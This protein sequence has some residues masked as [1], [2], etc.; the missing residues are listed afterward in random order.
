MRWSVLGLLLIG[1]CTDT[2]PVEE[3]PTGPVLRIAATE[4]LRHNLVPALAQT[5]ENTVGSWT[6]QIVEHDSKSPV[7][8]LNAGEADLAFTSAGHTPTDQ[9]QALANGYSLEEEGARSIAAVD[10]VAVVTHPSNTLE[11]LTYDQVIGIFCTRQ[12]DNWTFLGMDSADIHAVTRDPRSGTRALFEDFFC[13]PRGIHAD[14]PLMPLAESEAMLAADADAITFASM[15]EPAG[16]VLGLRPDPVGVPVLPSAKNISRGVYPLYHDVYVYSRGAATGD[17]KA[18]LDWIASPAGQEVIDEARYVPLF[19]RPERLD[20][21]RPLRETIH[22]D[23]GSAEPNQRSMARLD[24]LVEELRDRAGEYRHI[25]LE[26]YADGSEGE[27]VRLSEERAQ[28]VQGMLEKELPGLF[29]EIIPRGATNPIAPNTTPYG[30]Q[31]NRRV[32]IYL[33]AEERIATPEGAPSR[34]GDEG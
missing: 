5:H 19:H 18:F 33:A 12:I 14:I 6:F 25:V 2:T 4:S 28:K 27:A 20:E 3:V 17:A 31:R 21:P 16:K 15:T 13:G 30:R 26:G 22:F 32:Q 9:E 29:F 7:A 1:A 11:S 23:A 10:V 24:M 8:L 34:G